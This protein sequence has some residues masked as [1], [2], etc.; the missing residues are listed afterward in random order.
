[1]IPHYPTA[2]ER[3]NSTESFDPRSPSNILE[4]HMRRV[5][6]NE[7]DEATPIDDEQVAQHWVDYYVDRI[8]DKKDTVTI[9]DGEPGDG[10]SN[11]T[12]WLGSMVRDAIGRKLGT[13]RTL[14][15]EEDVVYR[16]SNFVR[17]VYKSSRKDPSVVIADE[18]VLIGAQGS[19]GMSDVG[20]ILDQVLSIARIQGCTIFL[21]HPNI[22]GLASFVRNRRAKVWMHTERR[23]L[24]TAFTLKSAL[25]FTPPRQ[26]PFKKAKQP[27]ARI[28]WPNLEG[29]PI[30]KRYEPNK[31]EVTLETLVDSE[32]KAWE[33]EKKAGM[34]P[35]GPWAMDVWEKKGKYPEGLTQKEKD[36]RRKHESYHSERAGENPENVTQSTERARAR[37]RSTD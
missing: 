10:K 32:T 36:R 17:R 20:Q 26:L 12:L 31:I 35:P 8:L 2:L 5:I 15:L 3:L 33:I 16:L 13:D 4:R 1:M 23:G 28:R 24:T 11:F 25:D 7:L 6:G 27:W 22:W 37:A 30:W 21:L 18:G 14:N 9:V 29:S 19:S 34:R